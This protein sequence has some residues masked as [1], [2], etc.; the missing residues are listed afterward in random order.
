M[1]V[2]LTRV[3]YTCVFIVKLCI[4]KI[5]IIIIII[6]LYRKGTYKTAQVGREERKAVI[7]QKIPEVMRKWSYLRVKKPSLATCLHTIKHAVVTQITSII[8]ILILTMQIFH[9]CPLTREKPY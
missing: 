2:Y 8:I 4:A 7:V 5:V 9:L 3:L 1:Y 6:S